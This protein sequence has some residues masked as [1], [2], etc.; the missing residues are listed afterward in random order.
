MQVVQPHRDS[1]IIQANASIATQPLR[2]KAH[3]SLLLLAQTDAN[4][5][6]G[7]DRPMRSAVTL[8]LLAL[9]MLP[10]GNDDCCSFCVDAADGSGGGR[11][12]VMSGRG[13]RW[14]NSCGPGWCIA[15][16]PCNCRCLLPPPSTPPPLP[17]SISLRSSAAACRAWSG[18]VLSH[19]VRLR[20]MA[21]LSPALTPSARSATNPLVLMDD[22]Y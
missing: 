8:P 10:P 17:L 1:C 3:T 21:S 19:S 16:R 7:P 15:G 13:G 5:P 12:P 4:T 14:G 11:A 6:G 20:L 9:S 22:R 18:R 2:R